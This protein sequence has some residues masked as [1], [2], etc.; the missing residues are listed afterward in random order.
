MSKKDV[1][2][3]ALFCLIPLLNFP[4]AIL[5]DRTLF[6]RDIV[7]V[8]APQVDAVISQVAQGELPWLDARR[9][10]GQPLFADPRAEILYPPAWIHLILPKERSYSLFCA[11]HLVIAALGAAR[12]ARRLIPNASKAAQA[13]AG[14][15]FG[16]GGP[17]L[18][19][20]SHWHHLA[21]ASWMPWILEQTEPREDGRTPWFNVAGLVTLQFFAGSPDYSFATF[22]ACALRSMTRSDQTMK[23]RT[24]TGLALS[25][26]VVMG[27]IQLLP[28]LAFSHDA[29]REALPVGWALSPLHPALTL[30]T[31]VPF[32]TDSW[33]LRPE[34]RLELLRNAQVWMFSHYLGLSV[35]VLALLGLGY[36]NR[37]DRRFLCAALVLGLVVSWGVRSNELQSVIARI[38]LVSGLRFPTKHLILS[39]LALA[40][41]AA[42][43][44][45]GFESWGS[46]S[47]RWAALFGG[48]STLAAGLLFAW[49]TGPSASVDP[50]ALI[51]PAIALVATTIIL[52][53]QPGRRTRLL[54]PAAVAI[55]LLAGNRTINPTTPATLLRDRPPLTAFIP[56]ESRI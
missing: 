14:F 41:L 40:I 12:L 44:V 54:L 26:G 16:A 19:L 31:V 32:R 51:S 30:E 52:C 13:T 45:S 5:A 47:K 11:F 42:W 9:G 17:M 43:G 20:V 28:S 56:K 37:R 4:R 55:D 46:R 50:T 8:W 2:W 3:V 34:A 18:S 21:A 29:A 10:F 49:S 35:W 15:A 39:S 6:L 22:V 48:F 38:P 33:P 7:L 1:G 36:A 24:R 23:Q 53:A 25:L 27:A